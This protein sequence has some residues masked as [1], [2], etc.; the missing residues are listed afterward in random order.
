M[1]IAPLRQSPQIRAPFEG[2]A[3]LWK[4]YQRHS[5]RADHRMTRCARC[6]ALADAILRDA[7]YLRESARP[8]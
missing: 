1:F 4:H 3:A 2:L 5:R 7:E 8:N 6:E